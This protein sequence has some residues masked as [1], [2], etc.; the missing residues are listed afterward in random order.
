[1]RGY[2][3]RRTFAG[4]YYAP[5]LACLNEAVR[6]DPGYS[7][8]WA[9]LGWMHL[10]AAR[11][12]RTPD[13]NNQAAFDRALDAASHALGLDSGNVLALKALSSINHYMGNY[14]EGE[15]FAR[16]AVAI[17][18]NDPDSLAQLGWRLAVRGNFTEGIPYLQKAIQRTLNPPGWYFHLIAIDE[19][20]HGRYVEML[21]A[22][23]KGAIDNSGISWSLTAIAY[24]GIGDKDAAR[25]ALTKMAEIAPNLARD[26]GAVYRGHGATDAI[27]ETI[28]TGLRQAGWSEPVTR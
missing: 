10:D 25:E 28:V 11:F 19:C 2:A 27:V 23:K 16:Q 9:M 4:E 20:M 5:V 12:G 13:G 17:N 22:A 3:Y 15:K 8:A 21:A 18:P 26:P 14:A 1:L 6:R 24:G 7:E